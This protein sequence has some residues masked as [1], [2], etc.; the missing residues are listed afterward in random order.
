MQGKYDYYT[1]YINKVKEKAELK[2]KAE[3]QRWV[4]LLSLLLLISLLMFIWYAYLAN[5]KRTF[6]KVQQEKELAA[7]KLVHEQE[8]HKQEIMMADK[9]H[10]EE[11]AHK[12]V[13]LSVMR[14]YLVKKIEIVEKLNSIRENDVKHFVLSEE[15]WAELEVFLEGVED[16]FVTRLKKLYPNL[17][18]SDIRLMM[19]LRLKL[20]QK[21]LASIYCISEKAIKQKLFLY[22]ERVGIQNRPISLRKYI[23]RF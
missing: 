23:E 1:S 21:A 12:E 7:T 15:D 16:C 13:Q 22:K 20:S 4:S 2:G 14:N 11:L 17:T 6:L 10:K 9:L 19:L 5:K 3:M 8:M 18:Q